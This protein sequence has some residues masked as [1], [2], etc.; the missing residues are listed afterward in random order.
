MSRRFSRIKLIVSIYLWVIPSLVA[1]HIIHEGI[2]LL[3]LRSVGLRFL[4]SLENVGRNKEIG[5]ILLGIKNRHRLAHGRSGE[6]QLL[7][8]R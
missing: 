5:A 7:V 4:K 3:D 8:V 2:V 1:C 6:R